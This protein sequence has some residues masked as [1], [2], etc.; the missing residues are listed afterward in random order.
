MRR[1]WELSPMVHCPVVGVCLTTKE[2]RSLMSRGSDVSAMREFELHVAIIRSCATRNDVSRLID[3]TLSRRF[4]AQL[5]DYQHLDSSDT[6]LERWA[7]D[8][9]GCERIGGAM[10]AALTHPH[11]DDAAEN[12]IYGDIHLHQHQQAARDRSVER[13]HKHERLELV[14]LRRDLALQRESNATSKVEW[15]QRNRLLM[16]R[17]EQLEVQNRALQNRVD[18]RQQAVPGERLARTAELAQAQQLLAREQKKRMRVEQKL[19]K[20]NVLIDRLRD[21]VSRQ[22]GAGSPGISLTNGVDS[23]PGSEQSAA[24]LDAYLS[25][26][27]VLYVG[28]RPSTVSSQKRALEQRGA[29]FSHH[30]GGIEHG[31]ARLSPALRS[32]EVVICEASCT[33]HAAYW[34]VKKHCRRFEKPCL[35][36][37]SSGQKNM[38]RELQS[39][40]SVAAGADQCAA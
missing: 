32:A 19:G 5:R 26:R 31:I 29:S 33:S 2:V 6:L 34:R 3:K 8:L 27:K 35:F 17:V 36:L 10:W 37:D 40:A 11:C 39:I 18:S 15:E 12:R 21:S 22:P 20:A 38:I 30:D 28:G 9:A 4:A 7:R 24:G 1:L 16:A 13:L 25:G 14:Q 23:V